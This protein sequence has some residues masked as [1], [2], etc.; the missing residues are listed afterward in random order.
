M[1]LL[2]AIGL[3]YLSGALDQG[4]KG[5]DG[6]P[7]GSPGHQLKE[8]S[9]VLQ[10]WEELLDPDG[11]DQVAYRGDQRFA[12]RLTRRRPTAPGKG[13]HWRPD[14][15]YLISGGLG[16]LGLVTAR[17]MAEQGAR[18]LILFGRSAFPPCSQWDTAAAGDARRAAQ[19]AALV[20][21]QDL[22]ASVRVGS[23]DVA[24]EALAKIID[25]KTA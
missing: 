5:A 7:S 11:E 19:I 3:P 25:D 22:G 13:L 17:W 8:S 24:D 20:E 10:A 15:S 6:L 21:L 9:K 4:D 1:E 18:N 2:R 23:V 16:E 12:V 14:G